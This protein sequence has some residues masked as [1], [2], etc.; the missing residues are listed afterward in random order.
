MRSKIEILISEEDLKFIV[1]DEYDKIVNLAKYNSFCSKCY[2][3]K[4]V[5][6]IDYKLTINELNDVIFQGKCKSCQGKIARYVEI[7][8]NPKFRIRTEI[9][10]NSK[11]N[12][13]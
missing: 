8:E 2:G 11:V 9:I 4:T 6:M 10:K 5:E 12:K 3:K 7:G 1:V 13:N